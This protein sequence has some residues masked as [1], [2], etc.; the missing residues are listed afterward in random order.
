MMLKKVKHI[1]NWIHIFSEKAGRVASLLTLLMMGII[2]YEVLGRYLFGNPTKWAWLTN[3]QIFGIYILFAG[4]YTLSQGAHIR[5]EMF[6]D[7]FPP[8]IKFIAKMIA[9]LLFFVFIGCLIWQG[10]WMGLDSLAVRE[11]A[12]GIFPMPIYPLKLLIP[13]VTFLFLLEGIAVF[14]LGKYK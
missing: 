12:T 8:K 3:K 4:I 7:R 13:I 1:F 9:L 2:T 14:I 6:Y 10:A 5:I 11:K